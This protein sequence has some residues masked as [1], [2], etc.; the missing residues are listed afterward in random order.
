MPCAAIQNSPVAL[1]GNP[2]ALTPTHEPVYYLQG[3]RYHT[4]EELQAAL[5]HRPPPTL[6]PGTGVG[7]RLVLV[8][9]PVKVR[10][11]VLVRQLVRVRQLELG[12]NQDR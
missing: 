9:Q 1:G 6:W 3:S 2:T 10:Q 4:V 5:D 7:A 12:W 11:F 8:R